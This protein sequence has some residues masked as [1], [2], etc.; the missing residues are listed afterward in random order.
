MSDKKYA[1]NFEAIKAMSVDELAALL[2]FVYTTGLND[3]GYAVGLDDEEEKA[4]I[5]ENN[6]YDKEWLCA[7]AEMA[8]AQIFTDNDENLPD[9]FISSILRCA[10]IDDSEMNDN[11]QDS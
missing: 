2:D 3:G 6:P 5:L 4:K 9:A 11:P 8:T 7:E 10:G 1:N